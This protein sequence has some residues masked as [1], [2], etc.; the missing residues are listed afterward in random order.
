VPLLDYLV[1]DDAVKS[2]I[3]GDVTRTVDRTDT[4]LTYG[5]R[6]TWNLTIQVPYVKIE[7][8]SSL[9]TASTDPAVQDEVARLQSR[10]ISGMGQV[11]ITS[12][13]RP[14]FSDKHGFVWGYGVGLPVKHPL[15]P[16]AGRGTLLLDNPVPRYFGFFHYTF[17]P[18]S[19][20]SH[21]DLRVEVGISGKKYLGLQDG[22]EGSVHMGNDGRVSLDWNRQFGPFSAGLGL[23]AFTQGATSLNGIRQDDGR[24][25][26]GYQVML[27]FGNMDDLAQRPV[28][29]PYAIELR[30]E[31]TMTG[32]STPIANWL[33]LGV[34]FYF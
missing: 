31:H 3:D 26:D 15:S 10:T 4:E 12:L 20:D 13:H 6:D 17:Y 21:Y 19:S 18:L 27:G 34:R 30:Y 5:V 23:H 16:W 1:L 2:Q 29:F 22:G 32:T 25:E 14:V 9:T 24:R 11:R 8:N 28:A 33:R 7:Q